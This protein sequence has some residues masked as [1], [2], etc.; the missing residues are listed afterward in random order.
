RLR[1]MELSYY[2]NRVAEVTK[3]F[4]IDIYPVKG[5]IVSGPGPTKEDFLKENYLEYRLQNNVLATL[6]TSYSGSEGIREAFMKAQEVLADFRLSE[7]KKLVEKLFRE[8]NNRTGLGVYGLKDVMNLLKNN[9]VDIL[10]ITD[11]TNLQRLEVTCN[12]CKNI[13]EE[14]IEQPK[15]IAKKTD[16]LNKPC[17]A[18]K[19]M[20]QTAVSQD[21]VDYL[22]TIA[23][24]VGAKIEII[25]GLSEYG[26]MLSSLGK[27]AAILRYNPNL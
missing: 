10:L 25:S 22:S 19:S 18:C 5:L 3:E 9:V 6:D 15:L 7:E 24:P 20:D 21:I 11:D 14:I 26:V 13:Q 8:I 16:L 4:F 1:E 17:P 27:T 23:I 2:Y 12:R